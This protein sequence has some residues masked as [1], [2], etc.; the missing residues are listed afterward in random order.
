MLY[1]SYRYMQLTQDVESNNALTKQLN[2]PTM[3]A[4]ISKQKLNVSD[5]MTAKALG[6]GSTEKCDKYCHFCPLCWRRNKCGDKERKEIYSQLSFS[7]FNH[8]CT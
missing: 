7:F 6:T 1:T 8:I 2:C 3:W 5:S 4:V